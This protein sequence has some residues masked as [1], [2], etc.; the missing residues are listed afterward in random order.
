M[1]NYP[2]IDID[3][4]VFE[5]ESIWAEYLEPAYRERSPRIVLD[6]RGTERYLIEGSYGPRRKAG[7]MALKALSN[8]AVDVKAV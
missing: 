1:G 6:N 4:H 5:R 2:V 3:G 7:R 8:P